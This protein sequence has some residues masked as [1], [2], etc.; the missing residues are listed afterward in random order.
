MQAW[1]LWNED[2]TVQLADARISDPC[3]QTEIFRYIHVGLLCV[4]EF[5]K[6]RPIVSVVLSMLNSEITD[7]PNPKQPAFTERQASSQ[8]GFP[9]SSQQIF[10]VNDITVTNV[11][12][13]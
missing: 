11:E 12:G 3:F 6:D 13:R 5:A 2:K 8:K 4:Q 10:S 7:L 9:Q 1:K